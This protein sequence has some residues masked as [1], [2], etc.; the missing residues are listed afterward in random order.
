MSIWKTKYGHISIG[1][2]RVKY[3]DDY[4]AKLDCGCIIKIVESQKHKHLL[5]LDFDNCKDHK[6]T[7]ECED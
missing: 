3:L 4:T 1:K 5:E 2:R 6:C 7:S